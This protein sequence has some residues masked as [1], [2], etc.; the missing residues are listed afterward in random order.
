M[1]ALELCE[2]TVTA[3]QRALLRA[4]SLAIE[5]GGFVALVGP[6]GAGKTTLL[7]AALGLLTPT[8]GRVLLG[9]RDAREFTP[10]ERAAELA[11]LPQ[12]A[13]GSEPLS[14]LE[15]V[16]T[17]RYRFAE[18]ESA[19]REAA[20]RALS[21]VG[22][23]AHAS[24]RITRLSGGERQRVA[25]ATLLAQEARVALLDEPA[26]H[27]DP[28]QQL[29]IYRL[30]GRLWAEGSTLLL[31]THDL[32][33]LSQVGATERV[34]VVGLSQGRIEF[35]TAYDAGEL[36]ERLTELFGVEFVAL[37]RAGRRVLVASGP[38]LAGTPAAAG[39][40]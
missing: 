11:W 31:V 28:A 14:A 34:R 40:A 38:R 9:G 39:P 25:I 18:P 2:V 15:A 24:A 30:I 26:N 22:M 6:N 23:S 10:R 4:V 3:E 8:A 20:L 33:L 27:L 32:N 12:H 1:S 17:A 29:D 13:N 19:S 7:R 37:E 36:P 21:R 16:M 35:S 5:P